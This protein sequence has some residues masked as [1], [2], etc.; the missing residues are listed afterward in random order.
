MYNGA[1]DGRKIWV[2]KGF[3]LIE[4]IVVIVILAVLMAVAVP[5]VMSYMNSANEAKYYTAS[6][7]VSQKIN[8]ELTKF[9]TGSSD[10]KSYNSAVIS[11]MKSYNKSA[12]GDIYAIMVVFKYKS[13]PYQHQVYIDS[14]PGSNTVLN[15]NMAPDQITSMIIYYSKTPNGDIESYN[16]YCEVYPNKKITYHSK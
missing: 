7:T 14:Q 16:C 10:A 1:K 2:K 9:Y 15:S 4:I 11:A 6:R 12:T 8:V 13:V 5:S 3:T